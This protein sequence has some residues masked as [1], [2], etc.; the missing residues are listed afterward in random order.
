M[1]KNAGRDSKAQAK[2][3]KQAYSSSA[4]QVQYLILTGAIW[5]NLHLMAQGQ[6]KKGLQKSHQREISH[7]DSC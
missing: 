2:N 1:T 4:V 3:I 5:D 7:S 6:A